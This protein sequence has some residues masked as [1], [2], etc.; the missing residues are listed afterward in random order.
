MLAVINETMALRPPLSPHDLERSHRLGKR[1]Y[2]HHTR[3]VIVRFSSDRV[4]DCVFRP[5]ASLK[6]HNTERRDKPIFINEDLT[7]RRSKLAFAT[8]Q[9]KRQTKLTDCWTANGKILVKDN[10][11]RIDEIRNLDML[12]KYN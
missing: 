5:R 9:L 12:Q 3:P 10:S 7:A 4:R 2:E 6:A 11:N 8:R 1:R